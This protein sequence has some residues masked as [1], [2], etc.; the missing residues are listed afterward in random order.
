MREIILDTETTGLQAKNSEEI[1]RITAIGCVELIDRIP[2][3]NAKW[4]INPE[5]PVSRG[6]Y[7]VTGLTW[8][9]LRS[10][11]IFSQIVD[12]FLE[13]IQNDP[14]IIHNA[15]FDMGF[16]NREME[17]CGKPPLTNQVVDTLKIAR[18][19]F[20]GASNN[21]DALCKRFNINYLNSRAK[22]DA[23]D[24]AILLSK[25][26]IALLQ[27]QK[28]NL[29]LQTST[30]APKSSNVTKKPTRKAR[31]LHV[32]SPEEQQQHAEML[33]YIKQPLWLKI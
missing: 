4:Y 14:L 31:I 7:V 22:H 33:T 8:D 28:S 2:Q 26:Y 16:L 9:F 32:L 15:P 27:Q 12:A 1:H 23:L 21:L 6:A 13:F 24:D 11:S 20:P 17:M 5:R 29:I 25:V 18:A 30:V 3:R 10:F 19:S